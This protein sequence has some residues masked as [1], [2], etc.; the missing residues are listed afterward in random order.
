MCQ[1]QQQTSDVKFLTYICTDFLWQMTST[2]TDCHWWLRAML[3]LTSDWCA[4]RPWEERGADRCHHQDLLTGMWYASSQLFTESSFVAVF[5]ADVCVCLYLEGG[6]CLISNLCMLTP[7]L[8]Q[9]VKFPGW[10]MHRRASQQY[11]FRSYNTCPFSAMH[12]YENR[13]TCEC[14]EENKKP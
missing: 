6:R 2:F 1:C 12:F 5:E 10:M 8:P 14:E 4:K 9:A 3:E 11:I 7:S 13:F